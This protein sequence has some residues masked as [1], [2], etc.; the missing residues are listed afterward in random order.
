[1]YPQRTGLQRRQVESALGMR[2]RAAVP[3]E[4]RLVTYSVNRGVPVV[5]SH[6]RSKVGRQ[7]TAL[8]QSILASARRA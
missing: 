1:R 7:V 8:A 2:V 5:E 6:R 3:D 4:V